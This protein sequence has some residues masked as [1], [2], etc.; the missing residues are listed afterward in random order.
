MSVFGI[1]AFVDGLFKGREYRQEQ[2]DKKYQRERQQRMDAITMAQEQRA[3]QEHKLA[4]RERG[5]RIDAAGMELDQARR[6][7]ENEA[8]YRKLTSDLMA[9]PSAGATP[10]PVLPA[11]AAAPAPS[12][13]AVTVSSSNQQTNQT[14]AAAAAQGVAS[15]L[16]LELTMQ[17]ATRARQQ[18]I[19]AGLA[20]ALAQAPAP[21]NGSV[22]GK[23]VQQRAAPGL[24]AVGP[25]PAPAAAAA[26]MGAAQQADARGSVVSVRGMDEDVF[27]HPNGQAYGMSTGQRVTDPQMLSIIRQ[28]AATASQTQQAP[29]QN[30]LKP[31]YEHDWGA[32]LNRDISEVTNRIGAAGDAMTESVLGVPGT[33]LGTAANI[34]NRPL[35]TA[36]EAV[37]APVSVPLNDSGWFG[38]ENADTAQPAA[39]SVADTPRSAPNQNATAKP[40]MK[41]E[42]QAAADLGGPAGAVAVTAAQKVAGEALGAPG[43]GQM[44]P[45]QVNR[46]SAD[47][48]DHYTSVVAPRLVEEMVKR[49]DVDRALKYQEFIDQAATKAAMKDWSAAMVAAVDGNMDVFADKIITVYNRLDYYGDDTTIVREKSGFTKDAQGNINGAVLTFKDERTGNTWEQILDDPEQFIT[50]GIAA[51]APEK[52][53]EHY[54]AKISAAK[55]GARGAVKERQQRLDD[56]AKLIFTETNKSA[57]SEDQKISYADAMLQAQQQ[58]DG[59]GQ[60]EQTAAPPP[61]MRR[62]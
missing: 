36:L 53:F 51:T 42:A 28:Q 38:P 21:A 59:A 8:A 40:V 19:P 12:M 31:N 10:D 29:A 47:A 52:A 11:S 22:T 44:T 15:N 61:L 41:K 27:L 33:V 49:G 37:G 25:T 3:I 17:D 60:A 39:A 35:N 9:N 32:N 30:P 56:L 50:M 2:D 14:P 16:G 24:G 1:S 62:P 55:E 13:G 7:A 43:S 45:A 54:E 34:V 6:A 58:I 48:L 18:A 5:M 23:P 46:A 26:P 57:L 20:A 4:L